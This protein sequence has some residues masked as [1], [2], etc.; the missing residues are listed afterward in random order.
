MSCLLCPTV[1]S[2]EFQPIFQCL[3]LPLRALKERVGLN[4]GSGVIRGE[5]PAPGQPVGRALEAQGKAPCF[6]GLGLLRSSL[7]T[8]HTSPLLGTAAFPPLHDR[9]LL[10]DILFFHILGEPLTLPVESLLQGLTS[11]C[12]LSPL[13]KRCSPSNNS[14]GSSLTTLNITQQGG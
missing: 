6:P 1:L 8:M 4:V 5:T 2:L 13:P 3:S 12:V 11:L 14:K 10:V 7:T 9:R